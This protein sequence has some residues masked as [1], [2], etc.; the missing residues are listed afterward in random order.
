MF[1]LH[2][3]LTLVGFAIVAT[4]IIA[5]SSVFGHLS[6]AQD[7]A[8]P[9]PNINWVQEAVGINVRSGPGLNYD[10]IGQ[11]PA[12]TWVQP[13]AR[14]LAGD[15]IQIIY[16]TTE[17]WVQTTGVSWRLNIA[18]LPVVE[19]PNPTPIPPP[20]NYSEPGTATQTP[21]ANWVDVGV[22]SAFVRSGPGQGYLPLGMVYTGDVVDPVAHDQ[23]LD[24]VMIR[25]GDGYGWLRYDLVAWVDDIEALTV[26]DVPALTPDFT[27]VPVLPTH[28]PTF[29][30]TAITCSNS[31][32]ASPCPPRS[33][34]TSTT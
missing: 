20:Q 22:E 10:P 16:L 33:R 21:N 17:G 14:N 24:W 31:P 30:P 7:V 34:P 8:T 19:D 15:W 6:L 27:D 29:T 26:V 2:R 12:G 9:T 18:A 13:L 25:F 23:V 28:T 32:A 5:F 4:L 3:N 1:R 11:L